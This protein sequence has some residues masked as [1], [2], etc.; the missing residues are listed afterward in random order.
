M[1]TLLK[2]IASGLG[3]GFAPIAPGTFGSAAACVLMYCI[4]HYMICPCGNDYFFVHIFLLV[5]FIVAGVYSTGKLQEEWGADASRFTIDEMAGMLV[6]L[7]MLPVTTFNFLIAFAA[8]RFFDILKP[9]WIRSMEKIHGGWG[10][11]LD[12]LLA[13]VYASITIHIFLFWYQS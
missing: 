10:V 12:D 9:F 1:K 5:F 8:F 6:A 3:T 13:G 2:I 11:M 7:L 4:H